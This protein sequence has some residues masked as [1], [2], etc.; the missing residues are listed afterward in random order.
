MAFD[1]TKNWSRIHSAITNSKL[2]GTGRPNPVAQ[3][4]FCTRGLLDKNSNVVEADDLVGDGKYVTASPAAA[5]TLAVTRKQRMVDVSPAAGVGSYIYD[6]VLETA[7]ARKGDEKLIVA[8][9]PDSA[10]PTIHVHNATTAGTLLLTIAGAA[11]GFNVGARFVFD[12]T[13]W[14]LVPSVSDPAVNFVGQYLIPTPATTDA[15]SDNIVATVT[16]LSSAEAD[17]TVAAQP[18]VPRALTITT[19]DDASDD[20]AGTV[21]I[22]GTNAAGETVTEAVTIVA[23]TDAHETSNAF[24]TITTIAWD[25]G[26]TGAAADTIAIGDSDKL[27]IPFIGRAFT[28]LKARTMIDGAPVAFTADTPAA[29]SAQYG[30]YTPTDVPD[31][32]TS[33]L[34]DFT[35]KAS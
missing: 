6:I 1:L 25:F 34:V 23:G 8:T 16:D 2:F 24:R 9:M 32:A 26:A 14:E 19:S 10:N 3:V 22:T 11:Q 5:A 4:A 33:Y 27:G 20:L 21:T 13:A 30:T 7:N 28:I 12:G 29:T 17:A 35:Y 31:G 18:D 15:Q